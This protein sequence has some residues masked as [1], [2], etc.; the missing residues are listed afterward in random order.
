M[1][2]VGVL[3]WISV[4]VSEKDFFATNFTTGQVPLQL[5]LLDRACLVVICHFVC[6]ACNT[7]THSH[8]HPRSSLSS[9]QHPPTPTHNHTRGPRAQ[10]TKEHPMTR[11]SAFVLLTSLFESSDLGLDAVVNVCMHVHVG[12]A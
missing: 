1:V 6:L 12:E 3:R 11:P 9:M 2:A 8:S 7:H 5:A 4:S 10:V